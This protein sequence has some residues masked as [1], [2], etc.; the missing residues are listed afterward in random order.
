MLSR[1]A[2]QN[3]PIETQPATAKKI[4][5][6][7]QPNIIEPVYTYAATINTSY[8]YTHTYTYTH[9]YSHTYAHTVCIY[10]YTYLDWLG[11]AWI[12]LD[13]I[14]LVWL[15]LVRASTREAKK[16]TA[17]YPSE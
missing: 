12:G 2:G 17:E 6:N 4:K 15:G 8:A 3:P 16:P 9:T 1:A 10:T 13:W 14:D 11:W 7:T 5:M